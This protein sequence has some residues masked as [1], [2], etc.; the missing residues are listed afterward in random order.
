MPRVWI[1]LAR[2]EGGLDA[3]ARDAGATIIEGTA[4]DHSGLGT[5][6]ARDADPGSTIDSDE[7]GWIA[8]ATFPD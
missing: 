2:T 3:V 7:P 1:I 8:L 6:Y 5:S 4:T